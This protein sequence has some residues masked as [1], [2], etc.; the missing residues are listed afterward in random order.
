MTADLV[1]LLR[2][3]RTEHNGAGLWQGQLDTTLDPEGRS[4]IRDAANA[5]KHL[6]LTRVVSSDLERARESAAIVG[7]LTGL[8]VAERRDLRETD[9]G[10]WQ[11]LTLSQVSE[12]WPDDYAK[13]ARGE[14]VKMG[15]A[16]S[17]F[18]VGA[19]CAAAI[20]A[21]A[22]AT[23]E[24][25]LLVVGHGGALRLAAAQLI[26]ASGQP[27]ATLSNGHWAELQPLETGWRVAGWNL[28]ANYLTSMSKETPE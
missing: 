9:V 1:V 7:E 19:R 24:G 20:R 6:G 5:L 11:G 10:L 15:G 23:S 28:G 26:G 22:L 2:H 27:F 13:W 12:H 21:E 8:A 3:G 16:E 4:Q 25:T 18:D 14:H 17:P